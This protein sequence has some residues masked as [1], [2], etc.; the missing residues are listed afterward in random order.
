MGVRKSQL[1]V[2][3]DDATIR[4]LLEYHGGRA[5]FEVLLAEDG[6][7]A[8]RCVSDET[9]VLVLDLNMPVLDGFGCLEL[10]TQERPALPVVV[11]TAAGE[12]QLAVKAMKL[13]AIDYITKPFDPEELVA[14]LQNA[15]RLRRAERENEE[16]REEIVGG[17]TQVQFVAES[18]EMREVVR[19]AR[20]IASMDSTVMVTGESGVGKGVLARFIHAES[21][22]AGKPFITVSC[23][24]LP[25]ELLESELFGHEKG[26]FTGAA[27]RRIGKIEMARGGTLFLDEIGDLS[28]D[29]QPKLLN[30]L[31][32]REFQ[33]VGGEEVLKT[34]VRIIA[35]R[36]VEEG[37][38]RGDLYYR[39]SVIPLKIPPL[40][41][42]LSELA[43]L[44]EGLLDKIN[45]RQKSKTSISSGAMKTLLTYDW[46][47]NVRQLENILERS[48]AFCENGVIEVDDL[49]KE[50]KGGGGSEEI[51]VGGLA[52]VSLAQIERE[53]IKQTLSLCGGNKAE[54]ARQLEISEKSVYNKMRRHGLL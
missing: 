1:V 42:R 14:V 44:C 13:G 11:L 51:S 18:E 10:L 12:A 46:P 25:R 52:G 37:L 30:V 4:R 36:Q 43:E 2:A 49:P 47:G 32:D 50:V 33:R 19:R 22:R 40:R 48:A 20:K 7:D 17:G 31:Q 29:L 5:G 6:E 53:A 24:A 27:K 3:D 23:P 45:K 34:D 9:D 26:A 38:F 8:M 28:L 54:T 15:K 35:E 16:L 41:E 21:N 39:L